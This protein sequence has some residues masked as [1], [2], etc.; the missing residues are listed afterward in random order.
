VVS[1]GWYDTTI[2]RDDGSPTY[3][4][5][6]SFVSNP[7]YNEDRRKIRLF[8]QTFTVAFDQVFDGT[9]PS[10]KVRG[11]KG[12]ASIR[13]W[14]LAGARRRASGTCQQTRW[15]AGSG[16]SCMLLCGLS[17]DRSSQPSLEGG[18]WEWGGSNQMETL[19]QNVRDKIMAVEAVRVR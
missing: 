8:D 14:G 18:V 7:I 2:R 10:Q 3:I 1:Y 15:T 9:T 6:A 17:A 5:N 4:P 12:G 19:K 13:H 11:G 16:H